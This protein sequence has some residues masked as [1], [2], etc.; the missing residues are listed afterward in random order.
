VKNI[1]LISLVFAVAA[2][3]HAQQPVTSA[4]IQAAAKEPQ[5]WLTYSGDYNGQRYS[6][7]TQV[8]PAN[9]KNLNLEWV[10]QVRSLGAAD[11]FEAT[12]LVVDGVM[13]TV[14]PPN[15]VVA[16]DAVTGRQF[17][18]YNY[19]VAQEA[20]PCC[21]RVNRGLA[22]LGNS[23]FMGTLDG[24]V[25]A[26]NAKTGEVQWNVAIDRPEVGYALTVAPLVVKDKVIVGPAGGEF[27]IRGYVLAL[28]PKT[29]KE[30][31]RFYTIPAPGEPGS[32]TWS[33]DAWKRGGG[34]IWV[35][36]S[37][38][39]ELNLMYWGV[40]NP[41]PDWNGDG[42]PG[43]NLYTD[44]VI[45]LD[46]DTGKLKWHYQFTPH[47]E[48]DYDATQIPVLADIQIGGQLRKVLMTAN[49]N[50]VFYVLDRTNGQFLKATPFTKVN[51]VNGWDA[52]GKP[53]RVLSPTP[54]G[55][56]VYP[57]NQGATN[58][59]S[60]SFSPRTGLFYIPTWADT[61]SVYRKT[62]GKDS[63][64]F[65][66]GQFFAGTFPTMTLPPMVGAAT[67]TRLPQEGYGTI[68]AVDPKTGERRWEFRM[69]DVTDS[70]ILSTATD[71]VF[72]GGREGYF[73]ALDA[74]TG[75]ILWKSMVGGQVA[76]G[77]M[78]YAVNGRQYVAVS[79]GNNLFVYALRQ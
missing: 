19:T 9:V 24:R 7:L 50:G 6:A 5:N 65:T 11:K 48:F 49:R 2:T 53:N 64:P 23:L 46:P 60:P 56:L 43:D 45:A 63:V 59:Y 36:G 13:Y 22:I 39:A 54:E 40:G 34:P 74:K 44:S 67:N 75:T 33:G 57:N 73:F 32:E 21:G 51:W 16:L 69:N 52:K 71:L 3:L 14:S 70:G 37:Y 47:D 79:A 41:G 78:S 10:F 17:W 4:R 26:L 61:Y 68:Q 18:R 29:G 42:R 28:D 27:G 62:P 25:V 20:R 66:E 76:S 35:T 1:V 8:T 77:P 15:D 58:W 12:P 55:T 31:W 72:A 30:L 38:D